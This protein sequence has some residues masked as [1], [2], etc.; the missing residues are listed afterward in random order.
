MT[1]AEDVRPARKVVLPADATGEFI[2][3]VLLK[4]T[5]TSSP[6]KDALGREDR[7]HW[8]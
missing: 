5:T 1:T 6:E 4:R 2:L 8:R 3:S 7:A